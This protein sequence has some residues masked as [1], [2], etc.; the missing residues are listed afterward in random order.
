MNCENICVSPMG[1]CGRAGDCDERCR[2]SY[3]GGEG[4]CTLGLCS[5]THGCDL[6][7]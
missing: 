7:I 5:C 1:E 6:R 4:S 3:D 2:V